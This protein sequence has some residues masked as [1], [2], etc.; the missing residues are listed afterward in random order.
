MIEAHRNRFEV[1][2]GRSAVL[3]E[4]RS[5]VGPIAFGTTSVE[6][7]VEV[8]M[9]DG[10]IELGGAAPAARLELDLNTLS[11][12]NSL[13]DAELRHRIEARQHPVTIVELR[14]VE[15]LGR[16]DR[17]QVEGDMTF[18]GVTRHD[19]IQNSCGTNRLQPTI[20]Q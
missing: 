3:I 16:S 4:A 5:T 8:D 9:R 18:H 15:R 2:S 1:N 11:S 14:G 12:G 19:F 7:R 6:G 17:Y 20:M 13:Y 10:A